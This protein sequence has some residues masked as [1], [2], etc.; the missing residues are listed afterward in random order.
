[1]AEG[2][3]DSYL[4]NCLVVGKPDEVGPIFMPDPDGR[5]VMCR[6]DGYAIVPR[7]DFERLVK[8]DGG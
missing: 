8:L 4:R 2:T 1:M 6:L 5:V 3:Y 7:Q